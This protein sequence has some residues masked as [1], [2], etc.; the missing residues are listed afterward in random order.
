MPVKPQLMIWMHFVEHMGQSDST[1]CGTFKISR[2]MCR[3][4]RKRVVKTMNNIQKEYTHWPG[5]DERI[6]ISKWVEKEFHIPNC[7]L[8]MDV[9]LLCL[10]IEPE[11]DDAAD[12]H[13][14][15]FTYSITV[16]VINNDK[17]QI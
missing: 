3:N 6:E 14:R 9:T 2:G 7:Q 15:K 8:M 16:N 17:R 13:R 1:Q 10:G 4:S 5:A 12:Y 11:C